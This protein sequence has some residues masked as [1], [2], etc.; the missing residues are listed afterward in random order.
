MKRALKKEGQ[1]KREMESEPVDIDQCKESSHNGSDSDISIGSKSNRT[2]DI[3]PEVEE[4]SSS[5][6]ESESEIYSDEDEEDED[7]SDDSDE[8]EDEDEPPIL[9]FSRLTHIPKSFF[10]RDSISS[11]LFSDT[12]FAF[13]THSGLLHLTRPDF[14]TIRTFKCHSSSILSI[15]TEG[16]YFATGS[17]DGTV[18]IG[19]IEDAQDISGF[20][21]KRPIHAVVLDKNYASTKTFVSGGMAGDVVLTQRNWLGNRTDTIL[22]KN[23]GAIVGIYTVD[24]VIFWMNDNGITFY[25]SISRTKLLNIPFPQDEENRPDL[26]WPKVTFPETDRAI[27]CWGK[28]IWQFKVSVSKVQDSTNH[29]G[30]I[31][32][33][34]ASSL[35]GVPDRKVELEHHIELNCLVAGAAAFKDDQYLCLGIDQSNKDKLDAPELK[36]ID[37]FNGEELHTY[38]VIS[39]SFQNMTLNDYHLGVHI[40]EGKSEYYLISSTDAIASKELSLEDRFKWYVERQMYLKAW[41]IGDYVVNPMQRLLVGQ[42]YIDSLLLKQDW[43]TAAEAIVKVFQEVQEGD[44]ELMNFK[45]SKW[46]MYIMKFVKNKH[47]DDIIDQVPTDPVLDYNV[48]TTILQSFIT[49]GKYDKVLSLLKKWDCSYYDVRTLLDSIEEELESREDTTLRRC[50][51]Q[52]YS[53]SDQYVPLVKQMLILKDVKVLD[54]LL[55]HNLLSNFVSSLKE[56]ILLPYN[57]DPINIDKMPLSVVRKVFSKSI[58]L[59]VENR[60]SIP[61]ERVISEFSGPLRVILFLFMEECMV[62]EPLMVTPYEDD[63]ISLYIQFNKKDLLDFL[64]LKSNYDVDRAIELCQADPSL[65]N[66]LIFLWSKI[67][68][69]RKALSLIIDRLDDPKLAFQ[70]VK[71]SNDNELWNYLINYSLDRPKFIKAILDT[72]DIFEDEIATIVER[73]PDDIEVEGLKDS[74]QHITTNNEL[75]LG[76]MNS[77]FKIVDD[78]TKQIVAEFLMVRKKGKAFM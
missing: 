68:E 15:A 78:E 67:G 4:D 1:V 11:C 28:H 63:M 72:S 9:T 56:I 55:E 66:E 17:I 70:F 32:S 44:E 51:I 29:I 38:Q 41:E 64:K 57:E 53:L 26:Y 54:V 59:L 5:G 76:V 13:G 37:I 39:K 69:N 50:L 71:D 14:T 16:D 62:L 12:L 52:I 61:I 45:I 22:E 47:A 60:H 40:G 73:V 23:N 43:S 24:D 25:S 6:T 49:A 19:S 10:Q 35:R 36:I 31:I 18:V 20:D 30:S 34:A 65:Y 21:F 46:G 77:I 58:L 48:Y 7:D 75:K 27:I 2:Q 33:S 74:L 8:D 42:Q 3:D